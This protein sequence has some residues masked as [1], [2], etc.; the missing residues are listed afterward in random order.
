M[1]P[2]RAVDNLKPYK[3]TLNSIT[4]IANKKDISTFWNLWQDPKSKIG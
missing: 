2:P 3:N 4:N 1:S